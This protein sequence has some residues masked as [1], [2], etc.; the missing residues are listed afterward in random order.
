MAYC[1]TA[2]PDTVGAETALADGSLDGD[3]AHPAA[4]ASASIAAMQTKPRTNS[5]FLIRDLHYRFLV[6][7]RPG[8]A[9]P[10][11]Q[12]GLSTQMQGHNIRKSLI[13]QI[14]LCFARYSVFSR[15]PL[16]NQRKAACCHRAIIESSCRE[17]VLTVHHGNIRYVA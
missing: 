2:A 6:A 13:S 16:V 1:T 15:A 12:H 3:A 10:Q 14:S 5:H 9:T 4:G 11:A 17:Y 7:L 8:T